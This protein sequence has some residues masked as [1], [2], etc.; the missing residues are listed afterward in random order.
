MNP[1][2]LNDIDSRLRRDWS[3]FTQSWQQAKEHWN[4]ARCRQFEQE[5]LQPMPG[6]MSQTSAAIAEFRNF[7]WKV[8]EQLRDEESE[9]E[10][11]V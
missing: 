10:F 7:A 11:F 4:D 9:N 6:V 8:S 2:L 5:D 3:T 1:A